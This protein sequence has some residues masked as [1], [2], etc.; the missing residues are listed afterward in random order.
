MSSTR[1]SIDTAREASGVATVPMGF[2]VTTPDPQRRSYLSWA[3]FTDPDG[4]RGLLQEIKERL[5]GRV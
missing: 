5:P 3:S 2:E 1:L 4:N